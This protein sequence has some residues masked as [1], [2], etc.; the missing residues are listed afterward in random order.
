MPVFEVK[1]TARVPDNKTELLK[2]L[3]TEDAI[4]F[5][6]KIC[7]NCH[8]V[9]GRERWE[10]TPEGSMMEVFAVGKREGSFQ[11]WEPIFIGTNREPYYEE[12]LNWEGKRD[13]MTQGYQLC[14]KD[15][16]FHILSDAFLVHRPGIKLMQAA[17]RLEHEAVTNNLID[18]K[19]S[20]ELHILFGTKDGCTI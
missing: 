19:I 7:P 8:A 13:K 11:H 4:L 16:E 2:M 12:R 14:V 9:P 10:S 6:K 15:Y 5:H 1:E 18:K 3:K 17:R 20:R